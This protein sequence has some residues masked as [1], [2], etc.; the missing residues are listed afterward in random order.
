MIERF[1]ASPSVRSFIGKLYG[2]YK[3]QSSSS[4]AEP[5]IKNAKLD[6]NVNEE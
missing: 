4:E 5:P 3:R 6:A 1:F 2:L